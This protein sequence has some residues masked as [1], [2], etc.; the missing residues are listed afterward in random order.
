MFDFLIVGAGFAGSVLAERIAGQLGKTCL[1]V[2]KR[3]HIGGNAH[4]RYDEAGFLF[5]LMARTI[6]VPI[7]IALAIISASSPSGMN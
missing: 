2:E 6:F 1:I 5:I 3:N 7:R 4:D